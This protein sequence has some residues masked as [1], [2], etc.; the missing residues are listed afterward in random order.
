MIQSL[1]A[2][3][4]AL[5]VNGLSANLAA[6][7]IVAHRGASHD[8]PE[9][10]LASINLAWRQ[11]AGA[12]EL[13]V[14]LSS[15]G[16]IVVIHDKDLKR[17]AGVDGK[18]VEKSFDE[19]RQLDVGEW[20][21]ARWKGEQM[22]TLGEVL[23]TIPEGRRMFVELKTG[24]EIVPALQRAIKASGKRAKQIVIISFSLAACAA[25]KKALPEHEVALI[26]GFKTRD[27]KSSPTIATLIRNAK[28]AGLDGLDL[29]A[30][31]PLTDDAAKRIRKA[32]LKFYVWT[33]DDPKRAKELQRIGVDG[34]T[35]NRPG[36]MR[37]Q[38]GVVK[39]GR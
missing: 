16:R 13:D 4:L 35:T 23:A 22:P 5:L 12:V 31:G 9:N 7:E 29:D 6:V 11:N 1:T 25:S 19:L 17:L 36:W 21:G 2:L 33:V 3:L 32:G 34:I 39:D 28:K 8:A 24:P 37:E 14:M 10:T 27:G 38:L 15:D 20:K 30:R 18:V 26:S